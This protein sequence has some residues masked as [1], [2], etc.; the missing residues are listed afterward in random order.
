MKNPLLLPLLALALTACGN[1]SKTDTLEA[2]AQAVQMPLAPSPINPEEPAPVGSAPPFSYELSAEGDVK[3]T[4]GKIVTDNVLKV[5]FVVGTDQGNH[6]HQASE[7]KITIAVGGT[8][9]SPTYNGGSV[10]GKINQSSGVIDLSPYVT[11]GKKIKIVLK[12]PMNDFYCTYSYGGN[13]LY[14]SY[15]GCYKAVNQYHKWT[16]TLLVQTSSTKAI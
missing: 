12:N 11:P 8:E 5:R 16:G 13:P 15:P 2:D 4:T 14:K 3:A 7:L 1:N 9:V 10:Y 6:I